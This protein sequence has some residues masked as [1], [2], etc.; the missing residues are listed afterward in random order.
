MLI[1][2]LIII[3]ELGFM[4]NSSYVFLRKKILKIADCRRLMK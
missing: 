3:Q 1:K 2:G 4:K